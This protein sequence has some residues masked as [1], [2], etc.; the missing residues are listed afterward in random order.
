MQSD[1]ANVYFQE[2]IDEMALGH[3]FIADEFGADAL[4]QCAWQ[5]LVAVQ[6]S[7]STASGSKRPCEDR[8]VR[9][10]KWGCTRLRGNGPEINVLRTYQQ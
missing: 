2:L 6:Q 10:H 7:F 9:A 8:S 5:V 3:Q 4:P 1:E